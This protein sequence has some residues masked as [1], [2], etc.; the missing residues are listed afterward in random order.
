M[1][2][3]QFCNT[4]I[5]TEVGAYLLNFI[6]DDRYE[7]YHSQPETWQRHFGYNDMYDDVFR[8]GSFMHYVPVDFSTETDKYR[9]WLWK[10]DYWNLH[11]G[12]EMGLYVYSDTY[13]DTEH[14]DVVD[15]ELP[16]TI[17]LYNYNNR[18]DID[19]VFNW[20]PEQPQWWATGFSGYNKEFLNP[21]EDLMV[22]V[23]SIDFTGKNDM[24]EALKATYDSRKED[25]LEDD[26]LMLI[27]DDDNC[28]MWVN[29]YEE[30]EN[31]KP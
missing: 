6:H 17:S 27:F 20:A 30:V 23:G 13:S 25:Y 10:G 26:A 15:F 12:A 1:L 21:N 28:K 5:H 9:L 31:D 8:I 29:W 11:S 3:K 18:N 2:V 4:S 22:V 19:N 14:Y 24:Y 16:M 7:A